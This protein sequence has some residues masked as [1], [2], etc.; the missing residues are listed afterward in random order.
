MSENDNTDNG[1]GWEE[2]DSTGQLDS[3]SS[4]DDTSDYSVDTS[5]LTAKSGGK[6]VLEKTTGFSVTLAVIVFLANMVA[7]WWITGESSKVISRPLIQDTSTAVSLAIDHSA[8]ASANNHVLLNRVLDTELMLRAAQNRHTITVV[9]LSVAFALVAIGFALFVMGAEGAF[10]LEGQVRG[11]S[12]LMVKATAPGLLCFVLA[13]VVVIFA[14]L[15]RTELE[16]GAFQVYP[17]NAQSQLAQGGYVGGD[18][19]TMN[20]I[21]VDD[22]GY[23]APEGPEIP[24]L[25]EG[26]EY[27]EEVYEGQVEESDTSAGEYVEEEYADDAYSSEEYS[28]ETGTEAQ[29]DAAYSEQ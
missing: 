23:V 12:N 9:S 26:G 21:V 1:S 11:E 19:A 16:P 27:G 2:S 15:S 6:T 17:D 28:D 24:P 7:A 10:R 13:T 25:E 4:G 5:D 29:A 18:S 14:L 3:N 20:A 8:G 22:T